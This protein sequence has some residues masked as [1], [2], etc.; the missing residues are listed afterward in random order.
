MKAARFLPLLLALAS[1]T[2]CA[3]KK[4]TQQPSQQN[5]NRMDTSKLINPAV[6]A[7]FDAWQ[8][9]DREAFTS[10]FSADAILLDDGNPRDFSRFVK[11]ACGHER[12]VSIDKVENNG[13][14]IYG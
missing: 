11:D 14:D 9:G 4:N 8:K 10:F 12:F 1:I 6:K 7:A 5:T 13:L 3:Q 2:A